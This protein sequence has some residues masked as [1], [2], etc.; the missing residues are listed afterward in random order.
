MSRNVEIKAKVQNLDETVRRAVEISGKQPTILK[1]HDIFYESPNGRLKMRS[2]E[3]NGV[4]HT[5]L[6]W[7]DRSDVAGPKLSN[8][9]KFDVPSEVL[10][11]LKLSLQS[12]MGVKGEVKKTRTLVLHGQTRIHIDRVDGLG[13]F[14]ELEVCL[15]PEETPEHG[16]KIA[17]EI[18][19][20][21]AVPETDLLTGAYM[22]M[23]KA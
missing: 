23:L 22:D 15:S 14:M 18:R 20:L 5:E 1:Q 6:I 13:D 3:E 4:A 11:A 16:E 9:N 12:S 21:L 17:H 10:D 7:Y 8:F 19:E 2:V